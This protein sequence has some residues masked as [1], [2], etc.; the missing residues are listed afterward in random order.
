MAK[1]RPL[2]LLP[3]WYLGAGQ[4]TF[5]ASTLIREA[6]WTGFSDKCLN[7]TFTQPWHDGIEILAHPKVETCQYLFVTG[8][9]EP[10]EFYLLKTMLKPGMVFIDIGANIGL[11]TL[12]AS[13]L[14]ENN[15]IVVA[16]EPSER[17][18]ERLRAN[19][20]LNKGQVIRLRQ[21]AISNSSQERE[22]LIAD[23]E[24]SG[25]NTFGAFAYAGVQNQGKQVVVTDTLDNLVQ[26]ES[27]GRVD[28]IK[29][30]VEG[31]ELFVLQ[32]AKKTLANFCP[33][34]L[35]EI[36]DSALVQQGC[37]SSQVLDFLHQLRYRIYLFS[38]QTGLPVPLDNRIE[39]INSENILA[40]HSS[41]E[42]SIDG[43]A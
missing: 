26:T 28:V 33:I 23:E 14:V 2:H 3:S 19:V 12:F 20:E 25:Q 32:G 24:H 15:G 11:Y 34:L 27:L 42:V 40:I 39:N 4:S 8:Y 16:I 18:M 41:S 43:I 35:V 17:E 21:T 29:I 30:D 31:H 9:Y 7:Q 10:N 1:P 22:L 38:K 37:S 13:K 6:L 5:R 36:S